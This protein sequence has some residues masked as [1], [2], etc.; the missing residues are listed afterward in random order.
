MAVKYG[1]Y[2]LIAAVIVAGILAFPGPLRAQAAP[3]EKP[4]KGIASPQT[5][6][7]GFE[8]G[9]AQLQEQRKAWESRVTAAA[10]DLA[11]TQKELD[12]FQL[13]AA[14]MK[15]TMVLQR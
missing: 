9:I 1:L 10:A 7:R 3:T 15:A 13:A 14:S 6:P 2:R 5:L 4:E 8:Q 12:K 11:Q